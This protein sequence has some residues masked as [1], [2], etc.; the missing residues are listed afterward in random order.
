[1]T[2]SPSPSV[3][4]G[5]VDKVPTDVWLAY[6]DRARE[7]AQRA[8]LEAEVAIKNAILRFALEARL[9]GEALVSPPKA[10]AGEPVG[11]VTAEILAAMKRGERVV[12]GWKYSADFCI[13]LYANHEARGDGVRV[14][15]EVVD[16][17][18]DRLC[19]KDDRSSPVEYPDM[20]LITRDE[21][22]E[23]M[24]TALP[25]LGDG[26]AEIVEACIA[27]VEKARSDVIHSGSVDYVNGVS[28][29]HSRAIAA[30]RS[31][32]NPGGGLS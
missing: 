26:R 16:R 29:G 9:S 5:L 1:M 24:R 15:D 30:I 25:P 12:P 17:E 21:L 22:A 19:E 2:K 20:A 32:S 11:W 23:A 6:E 13:P 4:E 7:I 31:L 8:R 10:G 3:D 28:L 14:T 27:A 18:W